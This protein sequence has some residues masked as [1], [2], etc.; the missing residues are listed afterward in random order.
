M[1]ASTSILRIAPASLPPCRLDIHLAATSIIA[2]IID[3]KTTNVIAET[4][5]RSAISTSVSRIRN[6]TPL[7][8]RRGIFIDDLRPFTGRTVICPIHSKPLSLGRAAVD[9]KRWL[10]A[11]RKC[12][13][14]D[15]A[16]GGTRCTRLSRP[17]CFSR[18]AFSFSAIS[19]G[20][21]E[22]LHFLRELKT[23]YINWLLGDKWIAASISCEF[24]G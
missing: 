15:L 16:P 9:G 20:T 3:A 17:A 18:S 14:N 23:L 13:E 7:P 19:S 1:L 4:T 10:T 12:D 5:N 21:Q 2:T 11:A 22:K 24:G 6:A 8:D